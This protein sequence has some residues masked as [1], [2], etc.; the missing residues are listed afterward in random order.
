[1][2]SQK[3]ISLNKIHLT[4]RSDEFSEQFSCD[5][6]PYFWLRIEKPIV[7]ALVISDLL[8]GS[9][10][11]EEIAYII[12]QALKQ[13]NRRDVSHFLFKNI[14]GDK[15]TEIEKNTARINGILML[16]ETSNPISSVQGEIIS[17]KHKYDYVITLLL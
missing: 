6:D 17:T 1:M 3:Y 7:N 9:L 12:S 4:H 8:Y 14:G 13:L 10:L 15:N 16:L 2:D 11:D 5:S